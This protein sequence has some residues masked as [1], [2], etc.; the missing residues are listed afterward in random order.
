MKRPE[1][2][3]DQ[4]EALKNLNALIRQIAILKAEVEALTNVADSQQRRID[5]MTK[6]GMGEPIPCKQNGAKP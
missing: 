2:N 3:R 6:P 4:I 5:N 1:T